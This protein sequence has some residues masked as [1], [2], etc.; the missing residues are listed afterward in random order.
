MGDDERGG[1]HI[2]KMRGNSMLKSRV[3]RQMQCLRVFVSVQLETSNS[4]SL[5]HLAFP[6]FFSMLVPVSGLYDR[7]TTE[8]HLLAYQLYCK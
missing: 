5:L 4:S 7:I 2:G 8:I 1:L 6:P 3:T